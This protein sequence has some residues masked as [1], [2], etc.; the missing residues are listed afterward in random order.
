MFLGSYIK[1][2]K[3]EQALYSHLPLCL[4]NPFKRLKREITSVLKV[5]TTHGELYF[6]NSGFI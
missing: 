5:Y 1:M 6:T 4:L 2:P 3:S